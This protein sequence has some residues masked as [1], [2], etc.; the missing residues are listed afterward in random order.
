MAV[1][2]SGSLLTISV[3]VAAEGN[4]PGVM[5]FAQR[6]LALL[7][8]HG[9]AATWGLDAAAARAAEPLAA[10]LAT[11]LPAHELAILGDGTWVGRGVSRGR[12]AAELAQRMS[13][14]T[15][16]GTK[17]RALLLSDTALDD[18]A[19]LVAKHGLTAI[20]NAASSGA[21]TVPRL[22]RFGLWNI[23][24]TAQLPDPGRTW[25]VGDGRKAC[26]AIDT[27]VAHRSVC[28]LSIDAHAYAHM[29]SARERVLRRV[30]HHAQRRQQQGLLR[31]SPLTTVA[32]TLATPHHRREPA[33]SILRPAA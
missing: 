18:H 14:V 4:T 27:A 8:E 29:S 3:D 25:L 1:A 17:P 32:A 20:R 16:L 19:D 28:H 33:R 22:V 15:A 26:R 2:L 13:A 11:K 31:T 6:L 7:A 24:A 12:F 10:A 30:F 5:Q 9:L 21:N 23:P